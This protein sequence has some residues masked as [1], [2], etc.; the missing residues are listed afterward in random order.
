DK[1]VGAL[2]NKEKSSIRREDLIVYLLNLYVDKTKKEKISKGKVFL[3]KIDL[4]SEKNPIWIDEFFMDLILPNGLDEH[5]S[6]EYLKSNEQLPFGFMVH[7]FDNTICLV[8]DSENLILFLDYANTEKDIVSSD[9]KSRT[10][11]FSKYGNSEN[12]K[13]LCE[14]LRKLAIGK[15]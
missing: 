6:I 11:S 4:D 2:I 9:G 14:H 5:I 1:S 10:T 13:A 3:E 7:E 12:H 8:E 15:E